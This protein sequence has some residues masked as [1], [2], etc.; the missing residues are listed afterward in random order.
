MGCSAGALAQPFI[1]G[2]NGWDVHF[3]G[4]KLSAS[5]MLSKTDGPDNFAHISI[6]C[7]S[8]DY[9]IDIITDPKSM[10]SKTWD[11]GMV[12]FITG[13]NGANI[14]HKFENVIFS[15]ENVFILRSPEFTKEQFLGVVRLLYD[16]S[17]V[18]IGGSSKTGG[19]SAFLM[20]GET[21]GL[22]G[23]DALGH[24]YSMCS[25]IIKD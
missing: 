21:T 10:S 15:G 18:L 3:D 17:S 23:S 11:K 14:S 8:D 13:A 7:E 16:N 6:T 5:A 2:H 22:S 25:N 12:N 24:T 9:S 4:I 20:L 19:M 1:L